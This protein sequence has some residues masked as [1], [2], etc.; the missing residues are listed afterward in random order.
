MNKEL[1]LTRI[2]FNYPTLGTP[3]F[4]GN[5]DKP[6]DCFSCTWINEAFD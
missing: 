1:Y 4:R 6:I 3:A 5:K 2:W